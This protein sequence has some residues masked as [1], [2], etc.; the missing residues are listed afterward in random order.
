MAEAEIFFEPD[1]KGHLRFAEVKDDVLTIIPSD[2]KERKMSIEEMV[3]EGIVGNEAIAYYMAITKRFLISIGID[4]EKLRFRQHLP[5]EMAHYANECWD[6][7]VLTT[8]GWIECVGI[9]DRSA[10]D[11]QAH[12]NA[13]GAD[14]TVSS[15]EKEVRKKIIPVSY[16]HLTLPTICSV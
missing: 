14:M 9:A 5:K 6:A 8:F 11:L 1:K 2:E 16:T 3:E 10:Y 13:T 4:E 7:E 15:G 12:M